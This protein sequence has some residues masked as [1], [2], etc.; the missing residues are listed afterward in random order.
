MYAKNVS[1]PPSDPLKRKSKARSSQ[2]QRLAARILKDEG[3]SQSYVAKKLGM[4]QSTVSRASKRLNKLAKIWIEQVQ[5]A[6][7]FLH[8][9]KTDILSVQV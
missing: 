2:S 6:Q 9:V 1:S 7:D 3:Y 8:P 5:A 4:S